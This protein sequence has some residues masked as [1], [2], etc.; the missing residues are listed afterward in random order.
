MF[1]HNQPNITNVMQYFNDT[2]VFLIKVIK[3]KEIL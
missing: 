2:Y 1:R 3:I